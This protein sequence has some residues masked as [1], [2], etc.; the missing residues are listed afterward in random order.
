MNPAAT[1][2]DLTLAARPATPETFAG[3]GDLLVPGAQAYLAKK[4]RALAQIHSVVPGPRRV[5]HLVRY[6][7]A[8]RLVLPLQG[9]AAWM[10][11]AGIGDSPAGP[12]AAFLIP[13]GTGV[14]L[15]AG[16]WHAGPRPLGEGSMLEVL[17]TPGTADRMDRRPL[18]QLL[19]AEGVHVLLPEEPGAPSAAFTLSASGAV[20]MDAAYRDRLRLACLTFEDLSLRERD[21]DLDAEM[22]AAVEG[23]SAMWGRTPELGDVP[24]VSQVRRLYQG[25]GIDPAHVVPSSETLL[26]RALDGRTPPTVNTLVDALSLCVLRMRVPVAG[27][28]AD[29]IRETVMVREGGPGESLVAAGR[30]RV[31]LHGRPALLDREGPFGSPLGDAL[32]TRPTLMTRRALVVLY[33]GPDVAG[34]ALESLFEGVERT[35]ERWCGG[36]AVARL[37]V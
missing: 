20:L 11:V 25:L 2:G 36:R 32:R 1:T 18:S 21:P 28:D 19:S 33:L 34:A 26:A 30:H 6:P 3:F 4:G 9:G 37:V 16:V 22:Q 8:R 24:G 23:V 31:R 13:S 29:C 14:L 27:F 5:T 17:E 10:V 12:P 7:Q 35:V 15:E